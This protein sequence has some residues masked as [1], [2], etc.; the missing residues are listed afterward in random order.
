[1][2]AIVTPSG[3]RFRLHRVHDLRRRAED[4]ARDAYAA[5]LA[6]RLEGASMLRGALGQRDDA[7]A[8]ARL[9][10]AAEA[11]SGAEL[12]AAQAWLDRLEDARE[13]VELDVGRRD[14]EAD[15]RR[16]SLL[17]AARERQALDRLEERA[18]ERH[19]VDAARAETA[20]LDELAVVGHRR[21]EA[22]R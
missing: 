4:Q 17:R 20:M 12:V 19:R 13:A 15:A 3:F 10:S 18:R 16:A 8:A 6:Y 7:R 1:M 2:T 9:R 22:S 14:A 21:A 5:S 11:A